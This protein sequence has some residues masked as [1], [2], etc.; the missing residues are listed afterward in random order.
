MEDKTFPHQPP[1]QNR[2]RITDMTADEWL[3]D[4]KEEIRD[5]ERLIA[6]HNVLLDLQDQLAS[7]SSRR[8]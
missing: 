2:R 3:A 5:L 8:R 4:L 7:D 6:E 1:S